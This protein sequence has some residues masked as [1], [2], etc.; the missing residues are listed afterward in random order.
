MLPT[1]E[2]YQVQHLPLVKAYADKIGL[3]EV[4]N[5]MVPT[6]MAVAPWTIVLG[7]ILDTLSGRSPLSR[8]EEFFTHQATALLLGQAIAPDALNDDPVGRVLERR[9]DT[10]T[11]KV[12][13]AC[14]VRAE[15]VFHFDKRY[16]HFDT[17]SVSV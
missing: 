6:E 17:T 11:M 1:I 7:M 15:Q 14:A 9:Y 3:V 13:T 16:V 4:I 10:G 5:Q 12:F 2:A 8:L